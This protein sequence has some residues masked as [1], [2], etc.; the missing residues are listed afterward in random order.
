[1]MLS[2]QHFFLAVVLFANAWAVKPQYGTMVHLFEWSWSDISRECEEF[3]GPA[4]YSA[5]QISPP[6]E[7]VQGL[8]WF[9]RYQPVSYKLESRS[10]SR[11][12]LI[13]MVQRCNASGV[14]IYADAVIN[15]MSSVGR[16]VGVA[17]SSYEDYRYPAVPY[18]PLDFHFCGRE[19]NDI[20][21]YSNAFEVRNC[22]L[23]NLADL[24]MEI[25]YVRDRIAD[26]LNDLLSIGVRGFRYDAAKHMA[27]ADLTAIRGRLQSSPYIFS[28]VIDQSSTEAIRASEY[29]GVGDVTEFRY[30]IEITNLMRNRGQIRFLATFGEGY[31]GLMRSDRAVV[32]ITNHDNERGHGGAGT[33]LTFED[34]ALHELASV[35][36][37]A[38][39]YGYP[40]VM[41]SY[42]FGT[43]Y[44]RGPPGVSPF[45]GCGYGSPWICQ[46]RARP[47]AAMVN[48]RKV[49][50][51][52]PV[53]KFS[54]RGDT[55]AFSR[56]SNAFIAINREETS[57][58]H[59]FNTDLSPGDYCNVLEYEFKSGNCTGPATIVESD[60]RVRVALGALK[61]MAL[62]IEAKRL[63]SSFNTMY[64]RGSFN[65]WGLL[66]LEL[67]ADNTWTARNISFAG[68]ENPRF[69]FDAGGDW[70]TNFGDNN[71][72]GVADLG[73][74]DILV[75]SPAGRKTI[76]FN[77]ATLQYSMLTSP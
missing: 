71:S 19:N 35:L 24:K 18:S 15:H 76:T 53:T 59:S 30:S 68:N 54:F 45:A 10:G 50:A 47:I 20:K 77:D 7:H 61:A 29:F 49:A 13:D 58:E 75:S 74:K 60:G 25:D 3:L 17:G 52:A 46:H 23:V 43:D 12:Q 56:G 33:V 9:T 1:M 26:Y 41:S 36:M 16:G 40:K 5:V 11:T 2:T 65:S 28:E 73:G 44:S 6:Q 27:V 37:L 38:W 64:L 66:P 55:V 14:A 34:Q 70:I 72:D 69:K 31:A 51:S 62:H 42:A 57:V 8:A 48:V 21:N 67:V 63:V 39:P 22:E 32:F 4:G